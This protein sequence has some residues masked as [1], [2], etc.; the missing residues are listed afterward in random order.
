M[1]NKPLTPKQRASVEKIIARGKQSFVWKRGVFGWGLPTGV[2]F[3]VWQYYGPLQMHFH[4]PVGR[5]RFL[6]YLLG[7]PLWLYA[8]YFWGRVMWSYYEGLLERQTK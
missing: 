7:L 1:F 8:G 6:S 4:P 2:L 3:L 5:G